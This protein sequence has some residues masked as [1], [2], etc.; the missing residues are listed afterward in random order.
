M[1]ITPKV[2]G[3]GY[4]Y[5]I[6]AGTRPRKTVNALWEVCQYIR[7]CEEESGTPLTWKDW[8]LGG[9]VIGSK[10]TSKALSQSWGLC[11]VSYHV[12]IDDYQRYVAEMLESDEGT[13][14]EGLLTNLGSH[15]DLQKAKAVCEGVEKLMR[16][17]KKSAG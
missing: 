15:Y 5:E 1:K 14:S 17:V 12:G 9:E 6:Q 13:Q 10:A 3:E 7:E 2:D 8:T 11:S 16:I 4:E